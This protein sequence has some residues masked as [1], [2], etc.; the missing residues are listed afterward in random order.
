LPLTRRGWR[1]ILA[2]A[3]AGRIERSGS[4]GAVATRD[5]RGGATCSPVADNAADGKHGAVGLSIE[6]P[7]PG[8]RGA[9][10]RTIESRRRL[11]RGHTEAIRLAGCGE[12][13]AGGSPS[14]ERLPD[15]SS[16]CREGRKPRRV[17]DDGS[18]P[19]WKV[20][21][22]RGS[23]ARRRA[24]SG[25]GQRAGARSVRRLQKSERRIFL[26]GT[27]ARGATREEPGRGDSSKRPTSP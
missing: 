17:A 8:M 12:A 10:T 20:T 21:A 16:R 1:R 22:S 26:A 23:G 14:S 2:A 6:A 18:A 7:L 24:R 5:V 4:N 11:V 9:R 13:K 3:N 27:E 25:I 15:G 19:S